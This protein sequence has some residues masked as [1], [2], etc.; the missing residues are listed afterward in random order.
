MQL[1][2]EI[3]ILNELAGKLKALAPRTPHLDAAQ[4]FVTEA[5]NLL[6]LHSQVIAALPPADAAPAPAPGI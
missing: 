4:H 1:T 5:A 2:S 6:G 3:H